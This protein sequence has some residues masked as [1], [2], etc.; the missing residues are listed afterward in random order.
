MHNKSSIF[1]KMDITENYINRIIKMN[2][3]WGE[4]SAFVEDENTGI[5]GDVA[6]LE[7][8]G[9]LFSLLFLL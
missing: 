4:I 6:T 1:N 2:R 9:Y 8:N 3:D 7:V 5:A